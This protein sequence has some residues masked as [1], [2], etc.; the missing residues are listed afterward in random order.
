MELK[1]ILSEQSRGIATVTLNRPEKRNAVSYE[2]MDDLPSH[3]S[4]PP[5]PMRRC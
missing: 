5:P 3:C 4:A 2:L 1:T